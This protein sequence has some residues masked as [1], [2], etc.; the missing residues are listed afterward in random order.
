MTF[1]MFFKRQF[2]LGCPGTHRAKDLSLTSVAFLVIVKIST[3]RY[4]LRF[5]SL[6][7]ELLK[8]QFTAFC[9]VPL[10]PFDH[11]GDVSCPV[12]H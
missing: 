3:L 2:N 7:S 12:V 10:W 1:A 9:V 8:A 4:M 6:V 11:Y 5:N